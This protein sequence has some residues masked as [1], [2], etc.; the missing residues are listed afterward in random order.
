M[1]AL[2]FF[3]RCENLVVFQ[4]IFFFDAFYLFCAPLYVVMEFMIRSEEITFLLQS[5]HL[6]L[7]AVN[8]G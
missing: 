8:H 3:S 2:H 1:H 7:K 6:N 5:H 4:R